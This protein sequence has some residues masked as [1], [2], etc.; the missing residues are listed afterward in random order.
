MSDTNFIT[1]NF[2]FKLRDI[3]GNS[4][5]FSQGIGNVRSETEFIDR[6]LLK[7]SRAKLKISFHLFD[8]LE[9]VDEFG[10]NF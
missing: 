3:L 2:L 5:N 8:F 4:C 6:V 9:D 10:L 7:R 1:L